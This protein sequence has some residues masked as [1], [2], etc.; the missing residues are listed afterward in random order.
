MDRA[1]DLIE[2]TGAVR[3]LFQRLLEAARAGD[4][5]TC[6]AFLAE[7]RARGL[8]AESIL[9]GLL[10]PA[11][12]Q[13]GLEWH[14]GRLPV[15]AEHRLTS[16]C[17]RVFSMLEPPPPRPGPPDLLLLQAPGNL[18]TLGA[19]IAGQVLAARGVSV[20]VVVPDL[21]LHEVADLARE[22]RPRRVGFSCALPSMVAPTVEFIARLRERLEPGLR[23]RYVLGGFAFRQDDAAPPPVVGPGIEVIADLEAFDPAS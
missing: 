9:L 20:R 18:H 6:A 17:D 3:W 5:H 7:A 12:Y 4:E 15:A 1:A 23:C 14:D 19:R 22:L 13:A 11:L 2:R 16:W 10:Q 8:P 21:P